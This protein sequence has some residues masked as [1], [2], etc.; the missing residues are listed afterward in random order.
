[1]RGL[2]V[3]VCLC[4]AGATGKLHYRFAITTVEQMANN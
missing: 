2:S 1:M 3:L 4:A